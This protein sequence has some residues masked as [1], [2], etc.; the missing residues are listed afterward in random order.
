[1]HTLFIIPLVATL[2]Y[3]EDGHNLMLLFKVFPVFS[4]EFPII[5]YFMGKTKQKKKLGKMRA[6][7]YR[8]DL[9]IQ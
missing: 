7:H 8:A 3:T 2:L 9:L 4:Q 6:K 5:P 1:M